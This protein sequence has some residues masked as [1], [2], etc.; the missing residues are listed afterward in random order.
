MFPTGPRSVLAV[1]SAALLFAFLLTGCA[2]SA[3]NAASQRDTE[4][5]IPLSI[6]TDS[7]THNYR[8]ELAITGQEQARGLMFRQ[9]MAAD[10]GMLFPF[11][12]ARPASFWMR[13]TYIPL[14]MIFISPDGTIES[15]AADT[16]PLTE[17]S[18]SS[19]GA[20]A[21]I[22]ELNGGEAARIGAKAGDAV[23]Y[24]LPQ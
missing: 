8:V 12:P 2:P 14:D 4:G 24:E 13:N 15:V 10:H 11:A 23:T 3:E 9:E 1:I 5:R 17:Q 7:G 20:V 6:V 21:A 18:Y 19:Q 16:V 22:L